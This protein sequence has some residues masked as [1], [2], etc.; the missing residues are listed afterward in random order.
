MLGEEAI[1]IPRLLK[2][3]HSIKDVSCGWN[4]S[5]LVSQDGLL[6]GFGCNKFNQLT[7]EKKT[8]YS[9]PIEI[10]ADWIPEKVCC[11]FRQTYVLSTDNKLH[12]RGQNKNA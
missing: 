5:L 1:M 4:H 6:F 2:I 3:E 8:F 9:E 7:S 11:G 10:A 12:G